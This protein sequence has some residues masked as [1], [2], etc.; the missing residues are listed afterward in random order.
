MR[1][2]ADVAVAFQGLADRPVVGEV[3]RNGIVDES[4]VDAEAAGTVRPRAH[5]MV[6]NVERGNDLS[7]KDYRKEED[8]QECNPGQSGKNPAFS[9][10]GF[11]LCAH[12][13]LERQ[14]DKVLRNRKPAES[15]SPACDRIQTAECGIGTWQRFRS[16]TTPRRIR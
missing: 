15:N 4:V 6:E 7:L 1:I 16:E 2:P 12:D 13:Q 3:L 11:R 8:R 14:G 10:F 9:S 5:Q